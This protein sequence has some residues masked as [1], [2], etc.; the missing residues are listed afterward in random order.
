METRINKFIAQNTQYSRRKADELISNGFVTINNDYANP[1]DMVDATTDIVRIDGKTLKSSSKEEFVYFLLNK[2]VN[3]LST[4]ADARGR[5][6]VVNF[7]DTDARI[8]PVGR[9]DYQSSGLIL[10]TNDGDLAFKM[11]HPKF[12]IPKKYIVHVEENIKEPQLESIRQGGI[13]I[14]NKNTSKTDI[15]KISTRQFEITLYQGI[16]RQI[17]LSCEHVGLTVKSLKRFAIGDL[18]LGDLEEGESRPLN[19]EEQAFIQSI[20]KLKK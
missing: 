18:M 8:F 20:K 2:P 6:T 10:L 7:I 15:R 14:E 9:L 16:K 3:V 19:K 5:T 17:R 1:G 12:H 4:V 13:P 11:T